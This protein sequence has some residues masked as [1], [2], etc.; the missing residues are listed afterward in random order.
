MMEWGWNLHNF[1]GKQKF[2]RGNN[3]NKAAGKVFEL[4]T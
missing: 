1:D 3:K 2:Q 4:R